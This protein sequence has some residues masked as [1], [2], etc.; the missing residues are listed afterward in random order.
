MPARQPVSVLRHSG[1]DETGFIPESLARHALNFTIFDLHHHLSVPVPIRD[2]SALIV[3]GGPQ[4]VNSGLDFLERERRIIAEAISYDKPVLGIC[5]GSQLMASVLGAKVF[6]IARSEIGWFPVKAT[7]ES[8]L[9]LLF[10][11]W[12][13]QT[14]FHWHNEGFDLP[15]GAVRLAWSDAC[16]NQAFRYG[17]R[18]WG[19]QFHPEVNPVIIKSWCEEDAACGDHREL[20]GSLDPAWNATYLHGLANRLF[21]RWA[22]MVIEK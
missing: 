18:H 15:A 4:S 21:D 17:D 5:L 16:P 2:A 11:D 3:L 19:I 9:D 7:P 1:G 6:R 13:E 22:Q 12:G 8:A 20:A 10:H 14:V